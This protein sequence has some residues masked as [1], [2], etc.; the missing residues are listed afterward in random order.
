MS[1]FLII[2]RKNKKTSPRVLGC[3]LFKLIKLLNRKKKKKNI[4]KKQTHL[5]THFL[6]VRVGVCV[7]LCG[8]VR[9]RVCRF[10]CGC[11]IVGVLMM[12]KL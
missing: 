4:A 12:I 7:W 3:L 10:L 1:F 11:V 8:C 5:K 2:F 6:C 9:V